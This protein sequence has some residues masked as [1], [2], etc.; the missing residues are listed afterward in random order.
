MDDNDKSLDSIRCINR[1]QLC[2]AGGFDERTLDR[3][4]ARGEGP[5]KT[6]LSPGRIGY[7]I[8][9]VTSWLNARRRVTA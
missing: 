8:V 7:R 4:E 2:K 5:T 9:D 1:R 3:L 6:Q